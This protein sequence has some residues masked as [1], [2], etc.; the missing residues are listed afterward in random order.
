MVAAVRMVEGREE[1]E[2]WSRAQTSAVHMVS[3][4]LST[5]HSV[6]TASEDEGGGGEVEGGEGEGRAEEEEEWEQ[7]GPKNKSAITR[8]VSGAVMSAWSHWSVV[9]AVMKM[10]V[11]VCDG[12]EGVNPTARSSSHTSGVYILEAIS[13]VA[14]LVHIGGHCVC[15]CV[16][17]HACV[18]MCVCV[19]S[20]FSFR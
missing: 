20:Q 2:G 13:S 3:P 1:G 12:R 19:D 4:F 7:V 5:G 8:Q 17:V 18:C 14:S 16:C 10:H 6:A 11:P 15:I 9:V